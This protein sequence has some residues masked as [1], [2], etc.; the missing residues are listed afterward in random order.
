MMTN[1]R[2]VEVREFAHAL[3]DA[4]KRI[5]PG[6]L[7]KEIE[8]RIATLVG[9]VDGLCDG[10]AGCIDDIKRAL[11]LIDPTGFETCVDARELRAALEGSRRT[12]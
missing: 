12:D 8:E 6:R 7:D 9:M 4:M 10:A 2:I 3:E 5:Y 1:D 11:A